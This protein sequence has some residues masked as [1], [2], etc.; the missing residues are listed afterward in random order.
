MKTLIWKGLAI[1]AVLVAGLSS[2]KGEVAEKIQNTMDSA[3]S[4][5]QEMAADEVQKAIQKQIDSFL[6]SSEFEERLGVSEEQK[7]QIQQSFKEY[8]SSYDFGTEDIDE[9]KEGLAD[10]AKEIADSTDTKISK[11]EI[12]EKLSEILNDNK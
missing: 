3:K 9:V 2:C 8:L 11:E 7:E 1:A 4:D 5:M 10:L 12:N 6:Q